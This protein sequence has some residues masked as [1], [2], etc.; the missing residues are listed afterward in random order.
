MKKKNNL[1]AKQKNIILITRKLSVA[2]FLF[3]LSIFS[4]LGIL[5]PL[6]PK[7]SE[8]E[9]RAL[10]KFP[11][12]TWNSFWDGNFFSEVSLWYSDTYPLRDTLITADHNIKSLFG[13]EPSVQMIGGNTQA[14][15]I[16]TVPAT[17]TEE[18][19]A[20][21]TAQATRANKSLLASHRKVIS[22]RSLVLSLT[23]AFEP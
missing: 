19:K 17:T 9:K 1:T 5:L 10:A 23:R 13:F 3:A 14:D 12:I 6:R 16:P 2:L 18:S 20:D 11:R 21:T 22:G 4:V 8:A 7:V 15:E